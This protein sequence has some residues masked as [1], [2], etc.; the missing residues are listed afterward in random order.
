MKNPA[1]RPQG[2]LTQGYLL[3]HIRSL[4]PQR[5]TG[6]ALAI[7]FI[8]TLRTRPLRICSVGLY[9]SGF[10][11]AYCITFQM[12]GAGASEVDWTENERKDGLMLHSSYITRLSGNGRRRDQRL[13]Q[14]EQF[15]VPV[16]AH[17]RKPQKRLSKPC[18]IAA[19]PH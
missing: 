19:V 14:P 11:G 5:A 2:I 9:L 6:N 10:S 1:A 16:M 13:H 17:Y 12:M 7:R 3:Y 8:Y 4:T 18:D 15:Q